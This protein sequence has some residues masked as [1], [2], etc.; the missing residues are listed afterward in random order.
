[1]NGPRYAQIVGWGMYVPDKVLTNADL[2]RAVDTSDEWIVTMT[3][4]RERHI[5]A[6]ERESTATLAIRAAQEALLVADLAASQLDLVIVATATPDMR[7]L[8]PRA[9]C[10]MP[11]APQTP[12]RST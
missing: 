7:S 1:M 9:W 4:I 12:A 8:P 2:A 3:G 5:V 6:N 10:K 11:W